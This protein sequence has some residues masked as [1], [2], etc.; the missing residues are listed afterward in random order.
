MKKVC[1]FT[2]AVL[3]TLTLLT[4]CSNVEKSQPAFDMAAARKG[5]DS[6]N[7]KFSAAVANGDSTGMADCYTTDAKF[8]A[9]NGPVIS[10]KKNMEAA[11][12]GMMHSGIAKID[13]VTTGLWGNEDLLSE[14]GTYALATKDGKQAD[15]GKYIVLWKKEDGKWK[16]FRDCFNSDMPMPVK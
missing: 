1:L 3:L 4:S 2:T 9:A 13:L 10:G 7:Q 8:M 15:K 12:G 14:E 11:F 6:G 16:I 5:I